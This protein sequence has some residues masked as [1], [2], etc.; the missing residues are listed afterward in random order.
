MGT[1]ITIVWT[2]DSNVST[3]FIRY[4]VYYDSILKFLY[5]IWYKCRNIIIFVLDNV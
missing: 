5:V 1:L 4:Q 3:N 2:S